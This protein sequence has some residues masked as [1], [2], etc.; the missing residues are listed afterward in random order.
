MPSN[1]EIKARLSDLS[2]IAVLAEA[3]S[4]APAIT[5]EQHDTFF[6]AAHGRLKLRQFS[7]GRGE[8]IFY[9]RADVAATK[10]S[11]YLI[12]PTGSP[13]RLLAVLSAAL[14]AQQTVIKTRKLFQVGQTRVHLDSVVGLGSFVE[15][16]V[17]LRPDQPPEE[18]HR[19][20]RELMVALEIEESDL[21]EGAYADLLPGK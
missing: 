12:A 5:I 8:L 10:Q 11:D 17:E 4:G 2:R 16:E 21:I 13:A 14:D 15:L 1:I 18:G 6:P 20:A 3:L 19:I 9:S 7:P